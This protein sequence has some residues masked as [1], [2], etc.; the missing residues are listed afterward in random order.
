MSITKKNNI[1]AARPTLSYFQTWMPLIAQI[2]SAD[3]RFE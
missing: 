3:Q 1:A 2:Q